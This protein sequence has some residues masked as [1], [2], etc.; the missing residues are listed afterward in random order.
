MYIYTYSILL[1]PTRQGRIKL[2][3]FI[4]TSMLFHCVSFVHTIA[5]GKTGVILEKTCGL[6][7]FAF[8][9]FSLFYF[10]LYFIL[11]YFFLFFFKTISTFLLISKSITKHHI[12]TRKW[13]HV[14]F[15]Y[16]PT[17]SSLPVV[18]LSKFSA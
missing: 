7:L 9:P 16:S 8:I 4:V 12:D 1:K 6:F 17:R 13:S 15:T 2:E 14:H 11:F 18:Y 3:S 5:T 10:I